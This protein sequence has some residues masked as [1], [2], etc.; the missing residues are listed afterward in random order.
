[1]QDLFF[2]LAG[3]LGLF[4]FGFSLMGKGFQ[5]LAGDKISCL[6]T[7]TSNPLMAMGTG[8]LMTLTLQGAGAATVLLISLFGSGLVRLKQG[9][10]I[11]L[12]INLG[13]TVLVYLTS[14]Q[15]GKYAFLAIGL[16][17]LL[18]SCRKKRYTHYFGCTVLGFGLLFI[19]LNIL[20]TAMQP[21]VEHLF[22]R[23]ILT[24]QA[25]SPL[26]GYL[27]GF[28]FTALLQNNLATIGVLQAFV[29]QVAISGQESPFLHLTA[30]LPFILGT[31]LGICVTATLASV[32]DNILTKRAVWA[33]WLII[34]TT[35][36]GFLLLKG[37]LSQVVNGTTLWLWRSAGA[38]KEFIFSVPAGPLPTGARLLSKEIAMAHTIY[39][40]LMVVIWLP[41]AGSFS[42]FLT[43]RITGS[44][45][46]QEEKTTDGEYLNERFFA[47][48]G[49]ALRVAAKEILRT[50]EIAIDMLYFAKIAFFK[51][52]SS[53]IK[54][55]GKKEDHVDALHAKVTLYLSTLLSKQN[56]LTANQSRYLTGL[57]HVVNDVERIADHAEH[58]GEFAQAKLEEKLPFSQLAMDELALL[59]EKVLDICKKALVALEADDPLLA[60]QVLEREMVIDNIQK[61]MRQN[62]INRLNQGRCWPGS[63]IVYL[64]LIANLER[65]ADHAANIGEVVLEG[66]EELI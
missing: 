41:L 64:E 34:G 53:A 66:K 44:W 4:L 50:G 62:H 17:F 42:S 22:A 33:H 6:L 7:R 5:Y 63:G 28:L 12:G 54:D 21:L 52:Q 30:V 8:F 3:G 37:P 60:K 45:R 29:R 58:I 10:C 49:I 11:L 20:T 16:G 25:I 36:L 57:I 61:E 27:L 51:G 1:M 40:L 48:P 65:V 14:V 9:I 38:A 24:Q 15:L 46:N 31:G 59:Y 56:I 35:T 43:E 13:A 26:Y 23:G 19:G 32:K 47:T 2:G 18:F 39:N 55:I